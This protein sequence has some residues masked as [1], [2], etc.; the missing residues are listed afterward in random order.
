MHTGR[1]EHPRQPIDR[2]CLGEVAPMVGQRGPIGLVVE[3]PVEGRLVDG[4]RQRIEVEKQVLPVSHLQH[5][6]PIDGVEVAD[7]SEG[8]IAAA[9]SEGEGPDAGACGLLA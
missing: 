5:R 6:E 8:R 9:R 3:H 4:L 7:R 2:K 1:T